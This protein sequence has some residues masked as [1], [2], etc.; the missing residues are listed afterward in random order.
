L[1]YLSSSK[2]NSLRVTQQGKYYSL[3]IYSDI[4]G[5]YVSAASS[6]NK[7]LQVAVSGTTLYIKACK[8]GTATVTLAA[9]DGSGKKVKYKIRVKK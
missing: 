6:N 4:E 1:Q 3:D 8:P 2:I 9:T 5:G 7:V